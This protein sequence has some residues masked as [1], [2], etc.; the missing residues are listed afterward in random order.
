MGI[1]IT[2]G[3]IRGGCVGRSVVLHRGNYSAKV[4]YRK[5]KSRNL[6]LTAN[7]YGS[8]MSVKVERVKSQKAFL[9][10]GDSRKLQQETSMPAFPGTYNKSGLPINFW[11]KNL[12]QKE[13]GSGK[14][15]GR[16]SEFNRLR[17]TAFNEGAPSEGTLRQNGRQL[18]SS[19]QT[20]TTGSPF[21]PASKHAGE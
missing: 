11:I 18:N 13:G 19:T 9:R 21:V 14:Q 8:L 17:Q 15:G 3:L 10:T 5:R 12:D 2:H 6:G 1:L 16:S 7:R 4:I 20:H